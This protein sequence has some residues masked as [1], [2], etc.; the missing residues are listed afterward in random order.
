MSRRAAWAS[1]LAGTSPA[2]GLVDLGT[3]TVSSV[4]AP[5]APALSGAVRWVGHRSLQTLALSAGDCRR[6][7]SDFAR[8]GLVEPPP[9]LDD[10]DTFTDALG[11]RY[12]WAEGE[13]GPM[14]HPLADADLG[15]VAHHPRPRLPGTVQ[16]PDPLPGQDPPVVV[17]DAPVPGLLEMCFGLRGNWQFL[18][19]LT[20][21]WRIANALLDWSLETVAGAY[22]TMLRALPEPPDLVLYGDD[23]GYQESMFLSEQDFRTFVRPRLRTLFSRI[24]RLTPAAL[25]FHCCGAVAP[26]LGDLTDL[27]PELL[28][29]QYDAKGMLVDDVRSAV[30]R[31]TILHGFT[32][33]VAL[34]HALLDGAEWSIGVLTRELAVSAPAIAA[35]VD[36]I[37]TAADLAAA[38]RAAAFVHTLWPEDWA[39][40][41]AAPPDEPAVARM[42]AAVRDDVL[43]LPEAE[44]TGAL[45][46]LHAVSDRST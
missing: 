26:I 25:C 3:S 41:R 39:R 40:V 1:L 42:L 6:L 43:R 30:G 7:G 17:A 28:N 4:R 27:G 21:N 9:E 44:L 34:G 18:A 46:R 37:G 38:S 33:L 23:Y 2:R 16:I 31:R 32:D 13:P 15:G 10:A 22:E 8:A 19:D 5:G 12:V 36:S 11:I 29:L 14:D 45:P 24:R 20:D 35:P